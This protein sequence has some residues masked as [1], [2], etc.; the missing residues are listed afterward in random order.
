M[1]LKKKAGQHQLYK[2]AKEKY[3]KKPLGE[4][5]EEK[6]IMIGIRALLAEIDDPKA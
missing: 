1:R 5:D 6:K 3:N 2:L 4:D